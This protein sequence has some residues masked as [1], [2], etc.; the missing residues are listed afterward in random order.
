VVAIPIAERLAILER[1]EG[2]FGTAPPEFR[3][4]LLAKCDWRVCAVGRTVSHSGDQPADLMG[5]VDGTVEVYSRFAAGE[6]PLLHLAHEGTWLGYGSVLSDQRR[7]TVVARVDTLFARIPRRTVAEAL[8]SHPEWWRVFAFAVREYGDLAVRAL[9]D[10][11]IPDNERRCAAVL[12]RLGGQRFPRRTRVERAEVPVTQD[13]LAGLV[14]VS[15]TTLVQLLRGLE[16]RR[17]VAQ[18]YR[19]VR[20]VDVP[21]L[22]SVAAGH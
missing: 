13:E 3:N 20:I 22:E 15:R 4:A 14:N 6:N 9:A 11:L 2:W 1:N 16:R 5:I 10:Q 19:A 21:G 18:E 7:V 17:L 8:E 12:L